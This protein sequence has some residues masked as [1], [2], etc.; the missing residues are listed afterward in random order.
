[1]DTEAFGE[2]DDVDALREAELFRNMPDSLIRTILL[3]AQTLKMSAGT[4]VVRQGEPG[5][6]VF[7]V[8][9]GVVEISSPSEDGGRRSLAYLGRGECL[10][11]LAILT[12]SPRNAD[13][14]VPQ[15]AEL[16]VI[17]KKLFFQLMNDHPGFASRLCVILAHRLIKLLQNLPSDDSK[18]LQGSLKF[19]DLAT[20][21]QTLITSSQ[22]GIMK[23][24]DSG[25][26]VGLLVFQN[27]NIARATYGH[28]SGDE[29]VHQLFQ[30]QLTADFHFTTRE[31]TPDDE[32]PDPTITAPAMALVLDSV[33]LQDE[34]GTLGSRIPSPKTLVERTDNDL[35]WTGDDG[36]KVAEQIWERLET[37]STVA[38]LLDAT[39]G[40]HYHAAAVLVRLLETEQIM[41][42]LE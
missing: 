19:F 3:Q 26:T 6:S 7:V 29:A 25:E 10:G 16:I 2:L 4:W 9:N 41:P 21:I 33:R 37:P 11:E 34:L 31:V 8:K 15:E 28:R 24:V 30:V 27:G 18:E 17:E 36:R 38:E 23:L 40:C 1:M 13:A 42:V 20:V 39:L 5:N 22:S 14:R 32:S 12:D 35:D